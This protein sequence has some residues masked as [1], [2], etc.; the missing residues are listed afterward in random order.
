MA[1][2]RSGSLV[3]ARLP[4]LLYNKDKMLTLCGQMNDGLR[5]MAELFIE[6]ENDEDDDDDE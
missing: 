6:I 2:R 5:S 3:F 1:L 4:D